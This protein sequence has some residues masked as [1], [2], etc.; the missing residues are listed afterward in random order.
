MPRKPD[1]TTLCQHHCKD[2][3]RCHML[4]AADSPSLCAFHARSHVKRAT[5][6]RDDSADL[7][8][9]F[10]RDLPKQ[11]SAADIH[12]H[13]WNLS[14]ALQ[15]GRI[16]PRR[17]AVL[18]YINSLLLRTLPAISQQQ[19]SAPQKIIIDIPGAIR[20]FPEDDESFRSGESLDSHAVSPPP[21]TVPP[22]PD[23]TRDDP[24]LYPEE[25]EG[26]TYA[27][28]IPLPRWGEVH[29]TIRQPE[30]PNTYGPPR[31]RAR[32]SLRHI[33]P[34]RRFKIA[35]RTPNTRCRVSGAPEDVV[36]RSHT[37]PLPTGRS[38]LFRDALSVCSASIA[39]RNRR[40]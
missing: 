17:A 1:P 21:A 8:A 15:Q 31:M 35:H 38:S 39:H 3:K 12:T 16:S 19:D 2:G 29:G 11:K 27:K 14:L 6:Q 37:R 36:L 10:S 4:L 22:T 26:P 40:T 24:P 5:A 18:A 23:S 25:P 28:P 7:S 30:R 20:H 33:A 34:R 13:L 9:L 32:R